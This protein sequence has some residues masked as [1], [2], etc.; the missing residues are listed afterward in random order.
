MNHFICDQQMECC[1]I[2][3]KDKTKDTITNVNYATDQ[4]V[5]CNRKDNPVFR[6]AVPVKDNTGALTSIN[7]YDYTFQCIIWNPLK[8]ETQALSAKY[9]A[10]ATTT[11]IA[12]ASLI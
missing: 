10:A 11:A 2:A 5:V 1:G 3:T 8:K 6:Y 4:I 9:L 7:E 12:L